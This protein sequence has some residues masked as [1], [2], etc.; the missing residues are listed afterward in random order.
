[1]YL[2]VLSLFYLFSVSK[3]IEFPFIIFMSGVIHVFLLHDRMVDYYRNKNQDLNSGCCFPYR[4]LQVAYIKTSEW[5]EDEWL[6][7]YPYLCI[8]HFNGYL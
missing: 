5:G 8:N 7:Y 2:K 3:T 6:G 1:M 4:T